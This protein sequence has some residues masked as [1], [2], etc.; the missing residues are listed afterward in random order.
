M[1]RDSSL[2]DF[3]GGGSTDSDEPSEQDDESTSDE[4]S[5]GAARTNAPD[6]D[7][8]T[9]TDAN[10]DT[11]GDAEDQ[12]RAAEEQKDAD[13]VEPAVSTFEFA[14][15]GAECAICNAVVERRW[16]D[17]QGLVCPDCKE[18]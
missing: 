1:P 17:E 7:T 6:A 11:D 15:D 13:S 4:K 9:A 8:E 2:D 16:R 12:G 10:E 18:W 14:P 5:S 3:L